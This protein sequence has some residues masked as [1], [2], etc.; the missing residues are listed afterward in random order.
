MK[1]K[2]TEKLMSLLII[3]LG[4]IFYSAGIALFLDPCNLAPGGTTGIAIILNFVTGMK[5]GTLVLLINIPILVFGWWKFGTKFI[6]S[7][8]YVT[9][10]SSQLINIFNHQIVMNFGLISQDKLLC[11]AIGGAMMAVGMAAIFRRG[12]T[13]GGTDII[14]RALRQR[15]PHIKSGKIFIISDAMIITAAAIVFK[16]VEVALYAAIT[17]FISNTVLDAVLYG[18]DKATLLYIISNNQDVISKRILDELDIGVT[19]LKAEGA[20]TENNKKVI[21]CVCRK[22]NYTKIR[23]IVRE[24][25]TEAF[26][27]VSNANEVFGDG[28]KDH[29]MQEI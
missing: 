24:E 10:L 28:Y 16:D 11:G 18:G 3:T 22:Y 5:T 14:V 1:N 15:Y 17:V 26:C 2:S 4:S 27:I 29:L 20:Y 19:H 6:L 12:A 21:M 13:T 23:E 7:T 9:V 8:V 25:D